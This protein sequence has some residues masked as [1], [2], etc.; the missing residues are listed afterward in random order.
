MGRMCLAIIFLA[1]CWVDECYASPADVGFNFRQ[2]SA[3]ACNGG[4]G[5]PAGTYAVTDANRSGTQTINGV[6]VTYSWDG[7]LN[8]ERDRST[9]VDCRLAGMAFNNND[10]TPSVFTVDLTNFGGPGTYTIH[11]AATDQTSDQFPLHIEIYDN[12]TLLNTINVATFNT[13]KAVDAAGTTFNTAAA[14]VSGE[15]GISLTFATSTFKLKLGDNSGAGA[16]SII[17]HLR[18]VAS[19]SSTKFSIDKLNLH[20]MSGL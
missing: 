14:W 5:D 9:T 7:N 10:G 13:P 19:A 6:S 12:T 15:Q 18:I 17:S 16:N 2:T 11:L 1:M 20:P 3:Y 4:G 8:G